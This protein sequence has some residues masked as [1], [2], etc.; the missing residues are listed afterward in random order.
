MDRRTV[1]VSGAGIIGTSAVKGAPPAPVASFE[2]SRTSRLFESLPGSRTEAIQDIK[3]IGSLLHS[4]VVD[5]STRQSKIVVASV[6]GQIMGQYPLPKGIYSGLGAFDNG[7]LLHA[8]NHAPEGGRLAANVL[9]RLD[10]NGRLDE[11]A[12][13]GMTTRA[14]VIIVEGP[15]MVEF[16]ADGSIRIWDLVGGLRPRGEWVSSQAAMPISRGA[17]NVDSTGDDV[18]LTM[19]DGSRIVCLRLGDMKA[20]EHSIVAADIA[21]AIKYYQPKV[22]ATSGQPVVIPATGLDSLGTLYGIVLP[23]PRNA[24]R[25]LQFNTSGA[26]T[27]WRSFQFPPLDQQRFAMAIK[28]LFHLKEC[29]VVFADGNVAWYAS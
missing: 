29:G 5:H 9:L 15:R 1:L 26:G 11:I 22:T 21:E 14:P 2:P 27:P 7:L 13:L 23:S 12:S 10:F 20:E 19:R 3:M 4:L 18:I 6:S 25:C 24:V 8:V 28:L 16:I 17:S